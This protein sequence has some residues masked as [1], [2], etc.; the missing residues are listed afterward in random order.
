[1]LDF[2]RQI[3]LS[4]EV[5]HEE[6]TPVLS[7]MAHGNGSI[8]WNGR[9]KYNILKSDAGCVAL[10]YL[11]I[12]LTSSAHLESRLLDYDNAAAPFNLSFLTKYRMGSR[13]YVIWY[14]AYKNT[15]LIDSFIF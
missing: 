4:T 1:V 15:P 3:G 11:L 2:G 10:A 7:G 9:R 13:V 5:Q 12:T 14:K 8:V 6:R